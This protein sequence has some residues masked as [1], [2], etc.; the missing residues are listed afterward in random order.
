MSEDLKKLRSEIDGIDDELARLI[1]RRA[2]LAQ[3]IGALKGSSPAYR[4]ERETGILRRISARKGV[5]GAERL[6]AVFREIISACRS[7]EETIRVSY[8]GPEGTFRSEE[9]RVGKECRL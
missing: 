9:R 5:L 1:D 2:G 7:L 6:V 8:L 3:R 4:P